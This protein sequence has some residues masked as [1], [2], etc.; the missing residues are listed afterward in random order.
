MNFLQFC[1]GFLS[2]CLCRR[3]RYS[4]VSEII[5]SSWIEGELCGFI[6]QST[7]YIDC[8]YRNCLILTVLISEWHMI[9]FQTTQLIKYFIY[10][11]FYF[12]NPKYHG[13][14]LRE[15]FGMNQFPEQNK[16]RSPWQE[17]IYNWQLCLIVFF[18]PYIGLNALIFLMFLCWFFSFPAK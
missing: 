3:N 7:T 6:F 11:Y 14:K 10:L 9:Y 12:V 17:Y 13:W 18:L 8:C 4:R 15:K 2:S 1:F 16:I 5:D